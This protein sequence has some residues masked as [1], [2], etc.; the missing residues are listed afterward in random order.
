MNTI[1]LRINWRPAL[2]IA[3]LIIFFLLNHDFLAVGN[4]YALMQAFALLGLVTLGISMTMVAGEFDLSV[5][6]VSAVAGLVLVKTGEAHAIL[7]VVLAITTGIMIGVVNGALTRTLRVSSLVTT[8]GTMILL[9]GLAVWLEGGKVLAYNNFEEAD[10]LDQAIAGIF[11]TRSLIAIGCFLLVAL[12]LAV[13]RLGRDIRAAGSHRKAAEMAGA[14]V[15]IALYASFALS[16]GLAALAGAL[17]SI[18]L[19]T[20]SSRF[21]GDLVLQAA[22]AAIIGGVTLTGGVGTPAGIAC[23]ALTLAILNNGL[24]LLGVPSSTILLLNG[25]MLFVVLVMDRRDTLPRRISA[26]LRTPSRG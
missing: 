10:L 5:G 22:T 11:S 6:A 23:G 16:G 4:V 17:T 3:L 19:S 25:T 7:G 13:T 20:A 21:G 14:N 8:L 24:S 1:L 26:S 18:S 9:N 15:S 2:P 12:I